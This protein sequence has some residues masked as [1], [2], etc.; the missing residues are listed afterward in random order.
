MPNG[1]KPIPTPGHITCS[2]LGNLYGCGYGTLGDVYESFMGIPKEFD[3]Y[4][5]KRMAFGSF[6]EEPVAQ[7][8]AKDMGFRIRRCGNR[9]W[10][11]KDMPYFICHPD[12]LLIGKDREGRRAA[13]EVQCV[14]PRSEDWGDEWTDQ[15]PDKYYLQCQG[16]FACEV[17]CDVVY[18][19]CMKGNEVLVYVILPDADVIADIKRRVKQAYESFMAGIVPKSENYEE[20]LKRLSKR[21]DK[22][23]EGFPAGD[24]GCGLWERLKENHKVLT[25]AKDTEE[26]LKKQMAE[27]MGDFPSVITTDDDGKIKR[28]AWLSETHKNEIDKDSLKEDLPDV[29]NKYLKEKVTFSLKFSW[30][31]EKKEE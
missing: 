4:Q 17:P 12:R 15:V 18:L 21:V 30:P 7:Y 25:A 2:Q 11:R 20:E 1:I 6:F 22:D 19:I 16:Y 13:I 28:I 8:F 24:F 26:A 10:W 9:A 31:K 27:F 23:K 5:L 3:D 14:S 29:Y